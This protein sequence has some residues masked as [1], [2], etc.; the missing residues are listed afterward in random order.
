MTSFSSSEPTTKN[1]VSSCDR[2][3]TTSPLHMKML[4]SPSA[5]CRVAARK[6]SFSNACTA[7]TSSPSATDEPGACGA[8]SGIAFPREH[9]YEG[10]IAHGGVSPAA[11]PACGDAPRNSCL[12]RVFH[13]VARGAGVPAR[14]RPRLTISPPAPPAA[15]GGKRGAGLREKR[16][17]AAWQP[18]LIKDDDRA[19]RRRVSSHLPTSPYPTSSARVTYCFFLKKNC[20]ILLRPHTQ[21]FTA[22][23][24]LRGT[25]D[26][27]RAP[28]R[29]S[30]SSEAGVE[31]R[32]RSCRRDACACQCVGT[33]GILQARACAARLGTLRPEA[34]ADRMK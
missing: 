2:Y 6:S 24:I 13:P 10:R 5:G 19:N 28:F 23:E 18:C 1:V 33:S 21:L 26:V 27:I 31:G 29:A 11:A 12:P 8:A 15:N 7:P 14:Y 32:V 34:V 9:V 25:W 3:T 30:P 4:D 20:F 22:A 17:G 16:G